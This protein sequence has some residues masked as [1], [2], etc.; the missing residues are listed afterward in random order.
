MDARGQ[1]EAP[2]AFPTVNSHRLE[3]N[4]KGQ[5]GRFG[6]DTNPRALPG[7]ERQIFGRPARQLAAAC[8]KSTRMQNVTLR[9]VCEKQ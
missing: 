1:L 4:L 3:G 6:G 5:S 9:C 2:A 7:I 8:A